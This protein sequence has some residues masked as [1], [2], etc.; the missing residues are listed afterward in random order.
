MAGPSNATRSAPMCNVSANNVHLHATDLSHG[1]HYMM[2]EARA[3]RCCCT[4]K[5]RTYMLLEQLPH[6][7]HP[8][9]DT[10]TPA[11]TEQPRSY[12][13]VMHCDSVTSW[14]WDVV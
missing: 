14:T 1:Q 5:I 10:C 13:T 2:P 3:V 9:I 7:K 4:N 8:F 12:I 11:L 6:K